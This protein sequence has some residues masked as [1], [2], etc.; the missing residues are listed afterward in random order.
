[1]TRDEFDR[2]WG[3]P[4]VIGDQMAK[5]LAYDLDALIDTECKQ[6]RERAAGIVN[7]AINH[8]RRSMERWITFEFGANRVAELSAELIILEGIAAAIRESAD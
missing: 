4:D 7:E 8:T 2:H 5:R 3:R 6:E 1:M